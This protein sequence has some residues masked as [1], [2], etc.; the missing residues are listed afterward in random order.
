MSFLSRVRE[1]FREKTRESFC[2]HLQSLG[3][4]VHMAE[5]G[6]AEE[7]IGN[8]GS[9]GLIDVAEGP[10]RWVNLHPPPSSG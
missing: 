4:D 7:K 9:L 6:R 2:A 10:I 5:R 1:R 8:A 3:I